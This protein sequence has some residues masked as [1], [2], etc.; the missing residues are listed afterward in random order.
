M[1][2][3]A[4]VL[5]LLVPATGH[6]AEKKEVSCAY[7]GRVMSAVQKARMNRV[8]KAQAA[9]HVASDAAWPENYSNAIPRL[10]DFV[11]GLSGKDWRASRKVDMGKQLEAQCLA[12][13][14]QI[15]QMKKQLK[16]N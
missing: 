1:L 3:F 11:Y 13:W 7:Q 10:V 16:K 9:A 14:D 4:L 8:P 6:A 2:R 5:A 15:Q 12:N